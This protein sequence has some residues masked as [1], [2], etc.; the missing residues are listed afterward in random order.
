MAFNKN[1]IAISAITGNGLKELIDHI[2]MELWGPED[3]HDPF[4]TG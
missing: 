2:Q 4:F 3:R 1:F